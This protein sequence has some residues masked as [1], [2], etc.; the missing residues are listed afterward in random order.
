[1]YSFEAGSTWGGDSSCRY[2]VP[3]TLGYPF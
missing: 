3:S 1:M 2:W